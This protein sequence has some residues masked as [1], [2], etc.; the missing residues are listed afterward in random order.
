[1]R[2]IIQSPPKGKLGPPFLDLTG[3]KF[4]R[5]EANAR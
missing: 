1:M 5:D 2:E 3:F 4:N